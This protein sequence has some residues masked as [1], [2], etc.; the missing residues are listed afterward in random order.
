MGRKWDNHG[1]A[2]GGV[3]SPTYHSWAGMVARCTNEKHRSYADYGGAGI[4]VCERWLVFANF[5]ADMGEKT[6]GMSIERRDGTKGYEPGNCCWATPKRQGRNKRNNRLMTL[7]GVTRTM[8]EWCET[9][10]VKQ[11]SLSHRVQAGWS[12]E[13]ALTK[14][15]GASDWHP[16]SR[17]LTI[18]GETLPV[19]QWSK[20]TGVPVS[21]IFYRLGKGANA[22]Q[23]TSPGRFK[24][25]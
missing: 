18:G 2:T 13:D 12:D 10:G 16:N 23:A 19:C 22:E 21:T 25:N 4:T 24:S 6:A 3:I 7:N 11:S 14:P 9:L 8:A 1:H 17:M 20:R 15:F 5:L